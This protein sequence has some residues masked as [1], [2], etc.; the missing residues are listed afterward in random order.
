MVVFMQTCDS[1]L[2]SSLLMTWFP[3]VDSSRTTDATEHLRATATLKLRTVS[4]D[5]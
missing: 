4:E 1:Y 5:K 2:H 3:Q